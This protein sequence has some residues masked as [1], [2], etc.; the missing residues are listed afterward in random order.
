MIS[1]IMRNP[2]RENV[3]RPAKCDSEARNSITVKLSG[4]FICCPVC[5][6]LSLYVRVYVYSAY[7]EEKLKHSLWRVLGDYLSIANCRTNGSRDFAE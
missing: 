1:R 5:L 4:N 6:S 7:T 2:S 3:Y